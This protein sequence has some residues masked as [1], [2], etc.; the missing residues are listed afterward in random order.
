MNVILVCATMIKYLS[1]C[2]YSINEISHCV[3]DAANILKKMLRTNKLTELLNN[4]DF[5]VT[6]YMK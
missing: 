2:T 6:I 1:G 5:T 3:T 4:G